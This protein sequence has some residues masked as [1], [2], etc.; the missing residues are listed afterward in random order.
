[1]RNGAVARAVGVLRTLEG[2]GRWTL[3]ALAERFQVHH[4]TIRRDLYALE[5][6]GVPLTNDEAGPGRGKRGEWWLCR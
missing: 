2:G 6:A 4:R 1:M 5:A 3:Y